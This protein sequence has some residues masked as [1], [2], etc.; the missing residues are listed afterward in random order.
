MWNILHSGFEW[1]QN[2]VYNY[3][4]KNEKVYNFALNT[5]LYATEQYVYGKQYINRQYNQHKMVKWT[6]DSIY[7][8]HA[9]FIHYKIE[10]F[11]NIWCNEIAIYKNTISD[12]NSKTPLYRLNEKYLFYDENKESF[13]NSTVTYI[14]YGQLTKYSV[15][16]NVLIYFKNNDKIILRNKMNM[17]Q[18][19]NTTY[20]YIYTTYRFITVQYIYK[21]FI[22]TLDLPKS[23]YVV[24]NIL[25][26]P[27]F[28][29]RCLSYQKD[30]FVFDYDYTLKLIDHNINIIELKSNQCILL[31]KDK[32]KVVLLS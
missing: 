19:N 32:Y 1:V 14:I 3:F 21:N 28:V 10:P 13:D 2:K 5:Y 25:M 26:T 12:S 20:K 6:I 11:Q 31:E 22:I 16:V 27:E 24:D 23:L 15:P 4:Q 30:P 29:Y 7:K 8:V 9:Y 18:Y 17:V